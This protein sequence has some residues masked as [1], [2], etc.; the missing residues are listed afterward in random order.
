MKPTLIRWLFRLILLTTTAL[1]ATGCLSFRGGDLTKLEPSPK[2]TKPAVERVRLD[3]QVTRNGQPIPAGLGAKAALDF[4][5]KVARHALTN[6]GLFGDLQMAMPGTTYW[7]DEF[8]LKYSVDNWG[9]QAAAAVSGFICG[10][11]LLTIPGVATDQDPVQVEVFD[12]QGKIR[13]K[14]IYDD[15]MTTVIWLGFVPCLFAPPC[16]PLNVLDKTMHNI[17]Q[18]SFQDMLADK[19]F[20]APAQAPAATTEAAK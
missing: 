9:S 11:T 6:S 4:H 16:Y 14:K 12:Y 2:A 8:V 7:P 19:V 20:L 18:H 10:F 17:Y 5:L 1:V 15:K 13:W 3:L